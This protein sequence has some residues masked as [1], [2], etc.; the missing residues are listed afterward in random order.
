MI[1]NESNALR[2]ATWD[3]P[4]FENSL[5]LLLTMNHFSRSC[6][7]GSASRQLLR[8]TDAPSLALTL[9]FQGLHSPFSLGEMAAQ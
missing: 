3:L 8:T 9:G 4:D 5:F 7:T 6:C 1:S 2:A